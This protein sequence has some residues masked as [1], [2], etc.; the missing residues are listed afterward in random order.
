[1]HTTHLSKMM[2]DASIFLTCDLYMAFSCY[3]SLSSILQ[4][5]IKSKEQGVGITIKSKDTIK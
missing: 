1:M 2:D 5:T 3:T 4:Y